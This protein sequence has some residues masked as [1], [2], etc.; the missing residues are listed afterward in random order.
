MSLEGKT[1][2]DYEYAINQFCHDNSG[3]DIFLVGEVSHPGISD[4]DFLVLDKAPHVSENVEPFLAGGNVLVMPSSL[5][6]F[7]KVL[8]NLNL[9][10]LQGKKHDIHPS[11]KML[12]VVQILEWLPERI[13]K[14]EKYLREDALWSDACLLHKSIDRSI[15][16]IEK[17]TGR[18]YGRISVDE[19][20]SSSALSKQAIESSVRAGFLAWDDFEKYLKDSNILTG[21]AHGSVRMC[22]YYTFDDKFT[23]LLLYFNRLSELRL[24]ISRSLHARVTIKADCFEI[25][26]EVDAFCA[27]RWAILDEVYCW[28]KDK[29]IKRGMIKYGWLL[30]E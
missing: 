23:A 29:Q 28:F 18:R 8:E 30:N 7:V 19:L 14:C 10:Q 12:Q 26:P 6:Q 9:K 11:P 5:I 3:L 20:R 13:L 16:G 17:I 24:P 25:D 27:Y 15:T 1:M 2:P 22:D 21:S 4:L